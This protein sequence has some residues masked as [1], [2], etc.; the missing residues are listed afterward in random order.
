MK[1]KGLWRKMLAGCLALTLSLSSSMAAFSTEEEPAA[2]EEA[3][4]E[5]IAEAVEEE[6]SYAVEED[7]AT[8]EEAVLEAADADVLPDDLIEDPVALS[9]AEDEEWITITFSTEEGKSRLTGDLG[10]YITNE[11]GDYVYAGPSEVT[12][13][14]RSGDNV[15]L[16]CDAFLNE[17]FRLAGWST[18]CC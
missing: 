15:F 16:G 17:G 14:V 9:A 3:A 12:I 1:N 18:D 8:E 6:E 2:P 7:D 11:Y 10:N 13:E 5:E 4:V